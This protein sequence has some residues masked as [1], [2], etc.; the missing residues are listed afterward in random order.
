MHEI[1]TIPKISNKNLDKFKFKKTITSFEIKEMRDYLT[2]FFNYL[3]KAFK[4]GYNVLDLMKAHSNFADELLNSIFSHFKLNLFDDICIIAVGGYGRKELFPKSD[5]D[6]LILANDKDVLLEATDNIESFIS[7]LWDLKLDLGNSVRT[8]E[9]AIDASNKD[10]S[11][12]TSLLENHFICGSYKV[13]EKLYEEIDRLNLWDIRSYLKGKI[14]EQVERHHR[15]K[16]TAYTLEPDIKNNPGGLRDIHVMQWIA[17]FHFKAKTLDD[18]LNLNILHKDE[19]EELL[20]CRNFLFLIRYALHLITKKHDDRFTLDYQK[21]VAELLGYGS[22][23]NRPV[24]KLMLNFYRVVRRIREYN[25][26][27]LQLETLR[28]TG[29]LGDDDNP[30]LINSYFVKR[31]PLIDI[32]DPDLFIEDPQ[33]MIEIFLEISKHEDILGLHV[34]CLRKLQDARRKLS[35]YLFE[36][37]ECRITFKK[38]FSLSNTLSTTLPLMHDHHILSAYLPQWERIEGLTQ[39]DMFHTFSV[40]EHTIRV[41][42]NIDDLNESD[43]E[44]HSLFKNVYHQINDQEV[45]KVAALLHDIAKGRGGHHAQEG[46][47]EA[48]YFCQI[49]GYTQYQT[50]MVSWLVLNHLLM[51]QVATRRDIS[52]PNVIYQFAKEVEDEE[53]LNSLYCL[54]VA[55]ISATNDTGWNSWKDS[56]F[57]QLYF[58]TRQAL[59]HGAEN[60]SDLSLH[61]KENKHLALLQCAEISELKIREFW[62]HI[63]DTYFAHYTANEISW[64]TK[65]I[66]RFK[67]KDKALILFSQHD[68]GTE[69]LIFDSTKRF[70]FAKIVMAMTRKKLNVQAAKIVRTTD[71]NTICTIMFQNIQNTSLDD[72]RLHSL[73]QSLQKALDEELNFENIKDKEKQ[74]FRIQPIVNFIPNKNNKFTNL[75]I[76]ALD[77]HGL[78]AKISFVLTQCLC[79]IHTA[80]IT[81][82]GE[83]A[84][85]FFTITSFNNESLSLQEM[86]HLKE[87]LYKILKY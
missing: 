85:D 64:H 54:S 65:N 4:D 26:M 35:Y 51:S 42:K 19:F 21:S 20:T 45:L 11:I 28:I 80:R 15:Y 83:R 3:D 76:S 27:A 9:E 33:K 8:I 50:K 39:F 73:R 30:I 29:H 24:E 6:L 56:I 36:I 34:N 59:R 78:L 12:K 60:P 47:K 62:S 72:E 58:A 52:D 77:T 37:P 75:E 55:D 31:G 10:I 68:I 49:H 25:S 46:A 74:I 44:I 38:I 1:I 53:H 5:I 69:V 22:E 2:E 57:R 43:L 82:T 41:L 14:K 66:L 71:N 16:D 81:T 48:T 63:D 17:N 40:D 61:V 87:E 84:D 7:Y 32:I 86:E 70:S 23:G 18:M 13:Y 79:R 67:K